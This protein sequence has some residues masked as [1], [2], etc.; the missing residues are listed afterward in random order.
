MVLKLDS[1]NARYKIQIEH[2]GS[3]KEQTTLDQVQ[4]TV[5]QFHCAPLLLLQ[6]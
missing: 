3:Q 1:K 4:T 5:S 6:L 2:P